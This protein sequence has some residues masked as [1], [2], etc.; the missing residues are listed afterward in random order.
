MVVSRNKLTPKI[1]IMDNLS[2]PTYNARQK[3][4][5]RDREEDCTSKVLTARKPLIE[6]RKRLAGKATRRI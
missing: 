6:A 5:S 3:V 4:Q 2:R 1:N